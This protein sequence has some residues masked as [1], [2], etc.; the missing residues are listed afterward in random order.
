MV[1][2]G[3]TLLNFPTSVLLEKYFIVQNPAINYILGPVAKIFRF[4]GT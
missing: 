2:T 1:C 4:Y 3:I